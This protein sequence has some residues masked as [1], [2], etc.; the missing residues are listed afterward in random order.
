MLCH[1]RRLLRSLL[2]GLLRSLLRSLLDMRPCCF[3]SGLAHSIRLY[4]DPQS[5]WTL[6][7]ISAALAS[8]HATS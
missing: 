3:P 6:L 2:R 8:Q 7:P 1:F 5:E 4:S